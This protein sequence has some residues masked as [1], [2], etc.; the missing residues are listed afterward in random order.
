MVIDCN[1]KFFDIFISLLGNVN[2]SIK[3]LLKFRLYKHHVKYH[4]LFDVNKCFGEGN[5]PYLLSDK[6][7]HDIFQRKNVTYNF[8]ISLQQK[9]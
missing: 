9:T 1:K 8:G 4:D 7:D 2:D 3:V 5:P 6:L